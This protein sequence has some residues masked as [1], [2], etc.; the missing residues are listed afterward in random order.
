MHTDD[1][2]R[3]GG[4]GG[5]GIRAFGLGFPCPRL[6]TSLQKACGPRPLALA[7]SA[8]LFERV[9]FFFFFLGAEATQR[10]STK[11]W[12]SRFRLLS[13]CPMWGASTAV[14]IHLRGF[15]FGLFLG[16]SLL[17]DGQTAT[18]KLSMHVS[19]ERKAQWA[20]KA[21]NWGELVE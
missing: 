10:R 2:H 13:A 3:R 14:A 7:L 18:V 16:V 12:L 1:A 5:G 20:S 15:G 6:F 21:A 19:H 4:G 8:P 17:L 11:R 9:F